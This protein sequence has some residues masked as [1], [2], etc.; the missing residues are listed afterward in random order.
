MSPAEPPHTR[1][2][3]IRRVAAFDFDGTISQR[4][5]LAGFLV[6]VAGRATV[7]RAAASESVSMGRGLTSSEQR[8]AAKERLLGRVLGG[9]SVEDVSDAGARYAARL[10]ERFRPSTIAEINRHREVGN[11]LVIV[12]ASL[13]YY[14]RPLAAELGFNEVIGVSMTELPD[15]RLGTT[16]D[17]PNVRKAEKARRLHAWLGEEPFELWAYGDSSGDEEL[18]AMADH[19]TW[20]GRRASRNS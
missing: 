4:D 20:V 18:L 1:D 8:N 16:L 11:D 12:S 10:P 14:L 13:V 9:R 17:G 19:A 2:G 3:S 15:G 7:A 6:F 5:T